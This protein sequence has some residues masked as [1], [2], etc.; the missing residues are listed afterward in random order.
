MGGTKD[1][2]ARGVFQ[3]KAE[4]VIDGIK[5]LVGNGN[6]RNNLPR[7][8]GKSLFYAKAKDGKIQQIMVYRDGVQTFRIESG[9]AHVNKVTH[10]VIGK[11]DIHVQ[12]FVDDFETNGRDSTHKPKTK[13]EKALAKLIGRKVR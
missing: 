1:F 12:N 6:D 2:K 13:L 9:H 4:A 7:F 11:K 8:A 10:E 3:Y 5:V